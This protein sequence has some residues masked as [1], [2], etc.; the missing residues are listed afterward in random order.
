[1]SRSSG[2]GLADQARIVHARLF[3]ATGTVLPDG[4][5]ARRDRSAGLAH[6]RDRGLHLLARVGDQRRQQR[7]RAELAVRGNDGARCRR[8]LG[9]I[10]EQHIAAAIDLHVD[11]ARARAMR[12]PAKRCTGMPAGTSPARHHVDDARTLR[13]GRPVAM[14]RAAVEHEIGGDGAWRAVCAH[15]VRVTFWRCRGRSASVPRRSASCTA[16][17]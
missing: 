10:V 17:A 3:A 5:R 12:R 2:I 14:Q 11:E 1:M 9:A 15:R 16:I 4:C 8:R 6:G 7:G 13:P